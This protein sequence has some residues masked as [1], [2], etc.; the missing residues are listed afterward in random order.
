M[1]KIK[2][3][4]ENKENIYFLK[5]LLVKKHLWPGFSATSNRQNLGIAGNMLRV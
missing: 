2:L 4:K 3:S 5:I 1:K